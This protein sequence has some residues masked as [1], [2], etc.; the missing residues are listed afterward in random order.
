L[1]WE[2]INI[3]KYKT[4]IV[5]TRAI[6]GIQAVDQKDVIWLVWSIIQ[7]VKSKLLQTLRVASTNTVPVSKMEYQLDALWKLYLHKWKPASKSKKLPLIYWT[8][9]M[10]IYPCDWQIPV[11]ERPELYIKACAQSNLLFEKIVA[12]CKLGFGAVTHTGPSLLDMKDEQQRM[13]TG[14]QPTLTGKYG[15][16]IIG[17]IGANGGLN[18]IIEDN[19][20]ASSIKLPVDSEPADMEEDVV[21]PTKKGGKNKGGADNNPALSAS[22][23]K[24]AIVNKLDAYLF[25]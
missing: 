16:K 22:M 24:I 6:E 23:N 15:A 1:F 10:L 9:C 4:F 12:Q 21:A 19:Y 3:K 18:V 17:D 8:L 14:I 25:S 7:Q 11:I 2:K 5:Q 13:A 20:K